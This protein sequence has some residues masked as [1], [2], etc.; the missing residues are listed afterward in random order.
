MIFG[1]STFTL[2]HVLI[3][4]VG[5]AA[6]IIVVTGLL[7]GHAFGRWTALF[8]VT[9]LATSITGFA[10]PFTQLLPSH[11]VGAISLVPL[12]LA[13]VARYVFRVVGAWRW[14]Y[15]LSAVLALYLNVFVRPALRQGA[16]LAYA[17]TDSVRA[18]VPDRAGGRAD[19]VRR[20]R[21]CRNHQIP[22]P[23]AVGCLSA[24]G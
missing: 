2:V 17:G 22:Q 4:L 18:A 9:T 14:V 21:H 1:V 15:V 8:L 10:F 12:T 13:I 7:T 24:L 5:I 20:A 11:V 23:A 19:G 16:G 3:S 6:G